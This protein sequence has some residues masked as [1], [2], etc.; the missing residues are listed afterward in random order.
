MIYI[1]ERASFFSFFHKKSLHEVCFIQIKE[2]IDGKRK[3]WMVG[4][5]RN[6]DYEFPPNSRVGPTGNSDYESPPNSRVGPTRNSDYESPPNSR[7]GTTR[8]S[9]Y[10]SPPNSRAE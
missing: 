3:T 10:E 1:E 5:T 2:Q 4:T 8:N 6:S 7:V 9:D